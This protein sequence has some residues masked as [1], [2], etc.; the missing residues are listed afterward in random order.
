LKQNKHSLTRLQL[1]KTICD[2]FVETFQRQVLSFI[3]Y[4]SVALGTAHK[5]SDIDIQVLSDSPENL[6]GRKAQNILSSAQ[7]KSGFKIVINV[8]SPAT[9]LSELVRGDTFHVLLFLNGTCLLRSQM[10]SSLRTLI[11]T[12]ELPTKSIVKNKIREEIENWTEEFYSY[13]LRDFMSDMSIS[14]FQYIAYRRVQSNTFETWS[15]QE[16]KIQRS[17]EH[18]PAIE[19]LLPEY[20]DCLRKFLELND[21]ITTTETD[22]TYDSDLDLIQLLVSARH[23][24]QE[25]E[26][27]I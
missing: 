5:D 4:G 21:N 9:I 19:E 22:F 24:M 25:I 11:E 17:S 27:A 23:I 14:I 2:K 26:T 15:E 8:K 20:S 1:A 13:R 16:N 12:K 10:F 7:K 6:T 3:V 18:M